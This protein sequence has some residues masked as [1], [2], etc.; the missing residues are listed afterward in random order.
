MTDS[1]APDFDDGYQK[2]GT[3]RTAPQGGMIKT[4]LTVEELA[5]AKAANVCGQCRHFELDD[6]QAAM[7]ATKFLPQLVKEHQWQVHHLANPTNTMG[8]CGLASGTEYRSEG[9]KLT[10]IMNPSC[11]QFRPEQ[12]L[13]TLRRKAKL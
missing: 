3:F 7:E 8:L 9:K 1:K 5:M 13:V 4:D 10:A 11:D 6:G 12:G 2:V